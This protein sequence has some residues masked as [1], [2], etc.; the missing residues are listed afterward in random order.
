M[1]ND[2]DPKQ[3]SV[4]IDYLEENR[5]FIQDSLEMALSLGDFQ[6]NINEKHDTSYILK[7]AEQ[8]IRRLIQFEVCALYLADQD[9]SD[10]TLSV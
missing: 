2:I 7:E 3:L 8:R 10:F 5:R 9:N 6:E 4:R 1:N